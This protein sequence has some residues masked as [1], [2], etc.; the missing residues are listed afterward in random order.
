M[1]SVGAAAGVLG[2]G[3]AAAATAVVTAGVGDGEMRRARMGLA[4]ALA[5]T[6]VTARRTPNT[7][8]RR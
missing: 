5:A 7:L 1:A 2:G 8:T 4:P 6:E 3:A